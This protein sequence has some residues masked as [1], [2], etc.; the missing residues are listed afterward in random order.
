[1]ELGFKKNR[2]VMIDLEDI[3]GCYRIGEYV[4]AYSDEIDH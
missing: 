3:L 2:K 4:D 1:M